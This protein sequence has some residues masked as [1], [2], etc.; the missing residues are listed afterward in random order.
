MKTAFHMMGRSVVRVP[1][2]AATRS[3]YGP[4]RLEVPGEI[5]VRDLWI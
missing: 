3:G 2:R 1:S 4:A 5:C